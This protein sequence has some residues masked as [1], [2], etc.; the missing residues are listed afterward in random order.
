MIAGILVFRGQSKEFGRARGELLGGAV[1]MNLGLFW[2][3]CK[4]QGLSRSEVLSQA[5][6]GSGLLSGGILEELEGL[7]RGAR[8]P[9]E[10]VLAYNRYEDAIHPAGCT[11]LVALGEASA[12]GETIFL[13]NSDKLG[14]K[15]LEGP[16]YHRNKEINVVVDVQIDGEPRI[17]GVAAAGSTGL[18][19]GLNDRGVV[20]GSNLARTK[21]LEE[22][23]V[24]LTGMRAID[25]AQLL[26]DGLTQ[27]DAEAAMRLVVGKIASA[28]M[29]TPGS[30]EFVDG[31]QGFIIEGFYNGFG[32][33]VVR[34]GQVAARANH[35]ILLKDL[36]GNADEAGYARYQRA[37]ELLDGNFGA[38]DRQKMIDFS[39]DHAN[40]PGAHSICRHARRFEEES[41]LSAAVMEVPRD[42][43]QRSRI[44]IALGKPCHAWRS[45]AG[46]V[47]FQ[48]DS[49]REEIPEGFHSGETWKT[50]YT[51]EPNT[52]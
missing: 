9:F 33:E 19:M 31:R 40:G 49:P 38:I 42:Q 20:A 21:D 15:T 47:S 17:V 29:S 22:K 25:R 43:P 50:F 34:E 41:S 35:F 37:R 46:Q 14:S 23:R 2:K 32:V 8:I 18:K 44:T 51:E 26:R 1:R 13:K 4:T 27:N 36:N 11:S 10:D 39:A 3:G 16:G 5:V 24:D 45:H 52:A 48:M 28:P 12:T 7:A 30:I 6:R